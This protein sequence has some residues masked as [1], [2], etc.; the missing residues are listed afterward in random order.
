MNLDLRIDS[1]T[2]WGVVHLTEWRNEIFID[3]DV[4]FFRRVTAEFG[5]LGLAIV[6]IIETIG[7]FI[8]AGIALMILPCFD[9]ERRKEIWGNMTS[10]LVGNALLSF[11]GAIS[12]LAM[13]FL[14]PCKPI[15]DE[16]DLHICYE[17]CFF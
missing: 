9:E 6:G 4:I 3:E 10:L 13:L 1:V 14:N 7:R 2:L 8:F 17:N 16:N 11:N 12:A 5:Y 15:L